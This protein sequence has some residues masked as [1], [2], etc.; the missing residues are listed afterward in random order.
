MAPRMGHLLKWVTGSSIVVG[1]LNTVT[2]ATATV[3]LIEGYD[4]TH[5]TVNEYF[6]ISFVSSNYVVGSYKLGTTPP[7]GLSLSP[8]VSE[9]GVGTVDGIPTQVG[10]Y[11]MDLFA[12]KEDNLTGDSTLLALTIYIEDKGPKFTEHPKSVSLSWSSALN[13]T[14]DL[15]NTDGASYQWVK[16]GI[17]LED[18]DSLAY[19]IE[20]VTSAAEGSYQLRATKDGVS[21]DSNAANVTVNASPIQ[22]WK[23]TA[24]PD[25]FSASTD[26]LQD[27]DLDGWCNLVE[28]AIG[29]DPQVPNHIQIPEVGFENSFWDRYVVYSIGK[30]STADGVTIFPE[31]SEQLVNPNWSTVL[32]GLNG[33]VLEERNGKLLVKVP[34][35]YS[36]FIR[37][38]ITDSQFN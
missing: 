6:R 30:S 37:F 12:Y 20:N 21:A 15:D 28:Y 3:D 17:V 23:E 5:G 34:T 26:E 13:L 33:M 2:G 24:F 11:N 35:D 10:V 31:F 27:P 38:R 16:D 1:G 9:F 25:P 19:H 36:L 32:N 29:T 8:N 7:P 22:M 18:S 14:A 4:N